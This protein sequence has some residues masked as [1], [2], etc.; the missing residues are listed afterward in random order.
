M[1]DGD[2]ATAAKKKKSGFSTSKYFQS[3]KGLR[4]VKMTDMCEIFKGYKK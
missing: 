3:R 4:A 2:P 1:T